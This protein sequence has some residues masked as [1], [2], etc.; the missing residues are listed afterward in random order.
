MSRETDLTRV[1]NLSDDSLRA[2]VRVIEQAIVLGD[3]W[4]QYD[5][6]TGTFSARDTRE[7]VVRSVPVPGET[8]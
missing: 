3:G 8:S 4:L 5:A 6:R 1:G 7:V 2:V